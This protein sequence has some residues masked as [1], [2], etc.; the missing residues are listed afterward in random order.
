MASTKIVFLILP[1]LHLL[2]LAGPDQVFLEAKDYGA[3]IDV[4]YASFTNILSTS[5]LLPL[6]KIEHFSKIKIQSGD[7][8]FVPGADI[9]YLQS[10]ELDS[11]K[12]LMDWVR[13]GYKNGAYLCSICTGAFF[14]AKTGLLD[15]K[16]CT[17]HWKRTAE[18]QSFYP[19]T[20]VLE[21][22]LFTEDEGIFTSAGVTAGI[23]MA[24]HILSILKDDL[25]SFKVAR[26]LVIYQRRSGNQEQKNIF[27]E[28]R[29]HIH[30][31]IHN[32]QEWLIEHLHE[33]PSIYHLAEIACM[34]ARNLTRVFK[35]ETGITINDY[36]TLLRQ[37][38]IKELLK[39]PDLTRSQM[40]YLCGLKSERQISRL[41][42][43]K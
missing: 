12:A 11:E 36:L 13:I 28:Y 40:A 5:T 1:H 17:T 34:S 30:T 31:S 43:Q 10:K 20:K 4:V 15:G 39:K 6:G 42:N 8:L 24:L 27:F 29:N 25:F 19:K 41:I 37:E 32:V 23:D 2:D 22:I 9:K 35:K 16:K 26:E 7:Y 18:L 3:D 14:L 21:N 33:K 38:K